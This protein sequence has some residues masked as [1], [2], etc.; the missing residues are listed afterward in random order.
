VGLRVLVASHTYVVGVNQAKLEAVSAIGGVSVGLLVPRAWKSR[1]WSRQLS[2]EGP[3]AS[4]W[5]MATST[6]FSGSV[7]AYIF[8]PWRAAQAIREFRPDIIQ[9]EQEAASL[10]ALEIGCLAAVTKSPLVVFGWE[11]VNKSLPWA[12]RLLRS[13]VLKL[14]ALYVAGSEGA[15]QVARDWG[16]QGRTA[17]LPQLGV[18]PELFSS[19]RRRPRSGQLAVGFVGRLSHEKGV[20]LLLRALQSVRE[21]GQKVSGI[22]CGTGPEEANLKGLADRM[23]LASA[24]E[25]VPAVSH[26]QVPEVLS[27]ISVLVLPSRSTPNWREQF[28][29]VLIEAMSMGIPVLGSDCGAI[30]EVIG[31][32]DLV[33]P[34]EDWFS[35]SRLL[36]RAASDAGWLAEVGQYGERRVGERYTHAAIARRLV[37]LWEEALG[38]RA[39]EED[40][41]T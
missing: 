14:T 3:P 12:R 22:I 38:R 19:G 7:G 6:W 37:S 30:P 4:V 11:N 41:S 18:D 36:G 16:Y 20:D 27:G 17:V 1:D 5:T 13:I 35:L 39:A 10:A 23:G 33:F 24:I 32:D 34:E 40:S 15:A 25:W 2:L 29:H 26:E 28:G 9:V 31:R 8:P 21:S